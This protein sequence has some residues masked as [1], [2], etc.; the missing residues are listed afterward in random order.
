[1]PKKVPFSVKT[2][3]KKVP[4]SVKTFAYGHMGYHTT[5]SKV[6]FWDSKLLVFFT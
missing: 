3:A 6:K 1:L 4:F 2:F 5:V